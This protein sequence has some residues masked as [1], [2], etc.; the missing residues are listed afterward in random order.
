M[1]LLD[2]FFHLASY[3]RCYAACIVMTRLMPRV[4]VSLIN[5]LAHFLQKF[6]LKCFLTMVVKCVCVLDLFQGLGSPARY[7][8]LGDFVFLF[9]SLLFLGLL[10][11]FLVELY[12][13]VVA[14]IKYIVLFLPLDVRMLIFCLFF[15]GT[16]MTVL[17][18]EEYPA[19][20]GE[21]R[22]VLLS[23]I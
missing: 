20:F 12:L 7:E 23:S 9:D 15:A 6:R 16:L 1:N 19:T 10:I 22:M 2:L 4:F 21:S 11:D 8:T 14:L 3:F 5:I 13:F 17:G 18:V